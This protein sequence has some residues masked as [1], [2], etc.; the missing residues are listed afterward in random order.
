M[1][2]YSLCVAAAAVTICATWDASS[3]FCYF[4][5]PTSTKPQARKLKLNNVNGC[6]NVSCGVHCVLEG[7]RIPPWRA[8]DR[9]WNRNVVSLLSS[10]TAEM[11]LP[12][13][14]VNSMAVSCHVPAVSIFVIVIIHT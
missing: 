2:D 13:S 3:Y 7:D 8:M 5:K 10:V 9:R 1:Q 11:R 6:N 14:C 12:L 4:F